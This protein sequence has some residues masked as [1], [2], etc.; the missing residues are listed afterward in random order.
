M[1]SLLI[2]TVLLAVS[3]MSTTT[4]SANHRSYCYDGRCLH[5]DGEQHMIDALRA[6][7]DLFA[8]PCVRTRGKAAVAVHRELG[9]AI[10]EVESTDARLLIIKSQGLVGRF[11]GTGNPAFL[12]SAAQ[13]VTQAIAA[14]QLAY[15]RSHANSRFTSNRPPIGYGRELARPHDYR[16]GSDFGY[17]AYRTP[18]QRYGHEYQRYSNFGSSYGFGSGYGSGFGSYGAGCNAYP[19]SGFSLRIGR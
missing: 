9:R 5:I 15:Q 11:V 7:D 17:N 3:V 4:A 12:D 10:G 1:K 2:A 16:Y 8:A 14:E 19:S 6:M 18:S 13:M